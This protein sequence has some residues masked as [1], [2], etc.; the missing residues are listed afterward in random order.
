MTVFDGLLAHNVLRNSAALHDPL[1]ILQL[2]SA[3]ASE[4]TMLEERTNCLT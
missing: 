3:V 2:L 1:P 4:P